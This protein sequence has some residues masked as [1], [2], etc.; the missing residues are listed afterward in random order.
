MQ[1]DLT[2]LR[3]CLVEPSKQQLQVFV[4]PCCWNDSTSFVPLERLVLVVVA[5]HRSALNF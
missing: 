4:W 2:C 3:S 1:L 5:Q